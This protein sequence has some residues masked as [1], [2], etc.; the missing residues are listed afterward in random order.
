MTNG[1]LSVFLLT[2]MSP[3]TNV[4]HIVPKQSWCHFEALECIFHLNLKI[5]PSVNQLTQ[6]NK[7]Q[8]FQ[9]YGRPCI[10]QSLYLSK[11][12]T[13][14]DRSLQAERAKALILSYRSAQRSL[15]RDSLPTDRAFALHRKYWTNFWQPT[16]H[17]QQNIFENT[18]VEVCN[19]HLHASFGTFCVKI[20]QFVAAQRAFKH[21]KMFCCTWIVC[22]QKFIHYIQ[23]ILI[24]SV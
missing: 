18:S 3:N 17:V 22:C 21:S 11:N 12:R 6:I 10:P 15:R 23:F 19:S 8:R 20:C 24:G 5:I 1:E 9:T 13:I 7:I 4:T 2:Y 14:V 16:I